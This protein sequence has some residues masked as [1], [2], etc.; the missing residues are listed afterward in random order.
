MKKIT[1]IFVLGFITITFNCFSQI[2]VSSTG[3][4]GINNTSPSYQLDV[5]GSFRISAS[6]NSILFNGNDLYPTGYGSSLGTY[7]TRWYYLYAEEP[8]FTMSP[9]IGS[10]EDFK[11]DIQ[12]FSKVSNSVIALR[13]VKY[14]LKDRINTQ[15]E[16]LQVNKR[17]MYGFIAQEVKKI[18]PEIVVEDKD[19][20][21]GIYYT[22]LI[23]VLV[24]ALQE[25]QTEIDE[26]KSRIKKLESDK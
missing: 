18:F 4:V 3:K 11:T 16:K 5:N 22:E 17:V 6:S 20:K 25:Q 7:Y 26:L 23:P 1:F 9:V 14:K 21:I 8:Y 24:K 2:K 15:G 13:P 19:G 12:S 10:D